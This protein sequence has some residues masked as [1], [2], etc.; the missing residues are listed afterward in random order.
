MSHDELQVEYERLKALTEQLQEQ[1]ASLKAENVALQQ[2]LKAQKEEYE[3]RLAEAQAQNDELRRQLF[4]SKAD[5]LTPEQQE[6]MEK[7]NQDLHDEAR[8]AAPVSDQVLQH[9]DRASRRRRKRRQHR[10]PLPDHLETETVIIE[11]EEKICPCCGKPLK[12]IGEEVSEEIDLIPAKLIRRRTI[13]P[14]FACAC[15]EAGVKIAPMPS[16]LIPQSKLGLGLGVHIVLSRFDDHLSYYRLEQQFK[17]RHGIV[18]PR[19]QMIQWVEPIAELLKPVYDAM[20]QQMFLS[21]YLQI[22]ETPVRVLDPDVKGKAAR[23][24]LWFYAVPGGDVI[25]EFDRSRGLAP[26]QERMK[27]F[28]GT[29]QTDAYEV[30]QSL[31]RK[32]SHIDRIGCMAHSRRRFYAA[33]KENLP[34]SVWFINQIRLLYQ[35]EDNVRKLD[36]TQRHAF[37]LQNAPTIWADLKSKAEELKPLFLPKSTMG[38]AI[39]YFLEEYDALTGYLRDGRFEI[40]NNLIENSIRPTAVGR[41]RW[42]FIGHPAAGWRSAVIY[43][44]LVSCRRRGINPQDYLMDVLRRLP[45]HKINRIDELLPGNWKHPTP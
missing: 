45:E 6:Q 8:R 32:E 27:G 17:E 42:L 5:R 26:V 34:Q 30:Y 21:G 29:I 13:R 4:G 33:L 14:K 10:H 39:S 23:G 16:R 25:L 38:K 20:W 11:P 43:S 37:R 22:D 9:E 36:P 3:Q 41:K 2:Q 24:Y 40:D 15:G 19:Q 31:E 18:I 12:K 35:I 44:I 1:A 28:V 7:L